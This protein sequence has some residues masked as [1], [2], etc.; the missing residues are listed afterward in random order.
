MKEYN[1]LTGELFTDL[2]TP[3]DKENNK[4]DV[5]SSIHWTAETDEEYIEKEKFIDNWKYE[6]DLVEAYA[7]YDVSGFD[8]W[9]L[10]QEDENYVSIDVI[11]K[12]SA[13]QYSQEEMQKIREIIITADED[14]QQGLW[15]IELKFMKGW[16]E[17]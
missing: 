12:K 4:I 17:Q 11:L 9:V 15:N 2:D 10:Q 16:E 1:I 7:W 13:E 5:Y 8:Y 6:D 3:F 14:L